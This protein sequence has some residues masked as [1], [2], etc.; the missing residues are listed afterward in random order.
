MHAVIKETSKKAR[1]GFRAQR[2]AYTPPKKKR[3]KEN[4][5]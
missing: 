1:R 2:T 4:M 3:K 5:E